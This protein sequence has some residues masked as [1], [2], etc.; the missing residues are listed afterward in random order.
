LPIFGDGERQ[1]IVQGPERVALTGPN[2][3]GKTSLL[4]ALVGASGGAPGHNDVNS[5]SDGPKSGPDDESTENWRRCVRASALHTDRVGF[6][7][8]RV[9]GIDESASALEV[10][11]AAAPAVPDRD[12]RNRLARF[13]IRGD[14]AHRP[15]SSLSGGERFRVAIARLVLA[16]PP[17]QLLVLDEPTNNLDIDTAEQLLEA[18]RAY[19][20]AVL[21][22]SHD[23]AFLRRLAPDLTL[24]LREGSLSEREID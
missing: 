19:R 20:G 16:D 6:L 23:D 24:E 2:G 12:L 18:L 7:P 3:S 17:P 1:W 5:A 10:V 13:L 21:I 15:V 9:D 8:Q 11:R 14:A 22:V 4:H